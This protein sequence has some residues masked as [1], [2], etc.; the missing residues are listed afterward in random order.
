MRARI[1]RLKMEIGDR[2]DDAT[3]LVHRGGLHGNDIVLTKGA[4]QDYR[5]RTKRSLNGSRHSGDVR[6]FEPLAASP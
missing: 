2:Y 3:G 4:A 6:R 5:V 1:S